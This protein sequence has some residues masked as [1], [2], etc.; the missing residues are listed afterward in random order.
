MRRIYRTVKDPAFI[1]AV[2]ATAFA[3][4]LLNGCAHGI[5]GVKQTITN[6]AVAD[7]AGYRTLSTIDKVKQDAIRARAITDAVGAQN[8]LIDHLH[9]YQIAWKALDDA[10]LV[11]EGANAALPLLE[12][13]L[14]AE[15]DPA[16]W[17]AALVKA[18]ADV[19]S[20]LSAFGVI[21]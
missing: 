1:M 21:K 8:E 19:Q 15:R 16:Q 4:L 3:A 17:I 7:A 14:K 11:I 5:D 13:G 18:A 10:S 20:A 6:V 9:K 2:A 12:K